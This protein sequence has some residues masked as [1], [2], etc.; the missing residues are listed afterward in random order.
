MVSADQEKWTASLSFYCYYIYFNMWYYCNTIQYNTIQFSVHPTNR[1]ESNR[2][3]T[4]GQSKAVN[5]VLSNR[6]EPN[7]QHQSLLSIGFLPFLY[8]VRYG[9]VRCGIALPQELRLVL[10]RPER[11]ASQPSVRSF[12]NREPNR[13]KPTSHVPAFCLALSYCMDVI[14]SNLRRGAV[15]CCLFVFVAVTERTTLVSAA[16]RLVSSLLSGSWF[17][18][19]HFGR[20]G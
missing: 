12:G 20:R 11:I 16:F 18:F 15:C 6:T 7:E 4:S 1:I 17:V 8:T 13:T 3:V 9:T 10:D 2:I 5:R 14:H 19:H